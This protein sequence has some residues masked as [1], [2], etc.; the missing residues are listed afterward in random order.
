[1]QEFTFYRLLTIGWAN[2]V[3]KS[4]V[5]VFGDVEGDEVRLN[6]EN[7]TFADAFGVTYLAACTM[8]ATQRWKTVY[9]R[10]PRLEKAHEFLV[11]VGF[12]Q[13]YGMQFRASQP[14]SDRVDLVHITRLQPFFVDALLTHMESIQPFAEGLRPSMRMSLFE[15]IQNF[16]E[17]S[18]SGHGAWVTGQVHRRAKGTDLPRVTLCMLDL[19]RGIPSAL[20]TVR[21]Y[22]RRTDDSLVHL[23]TVE[24]VS[25]APGSRGL[26]LTHIRN[27]AR[28]N[29]G[30]LNI[31]SESGYVRFRHD[32]TPESRRMT[33][34]F[35]GS[36][37]FLSLVPTTRGMFIL[38][39]DDEGGSQGG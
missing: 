29:G 9:V 30:T 38:G 28:V 8:A 15:L 4:T 12:Y 36:V 35:P 32:R 34:R 3:L 18:K 37:V 26:G 19:G 21:R 25:S 11:D 39:E 2:A 14:S 1:M 17:H 20:R 5:G 7:I 31:L 24:G 27:F 6:L 23:A 10:R 16:A 13:E 33:C 22:R